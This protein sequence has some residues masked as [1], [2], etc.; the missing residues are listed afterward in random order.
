MRIAVAGLV[1]AC[2]FAGAKLARTSASAMQE[3]SGVMDAF[4]PS[5]EGAPYLALGYREA[6]ADVLFVRLRGYFGGFENTADSIAELC[7]AIV[8]LDPRFHRPYEYCGGAMTLARQGVDQSSYL[9][10]AA[11]LERGAREFPND[12]RLPNLA[13]QIY[14]QDLQ[15]D[16]P[17]Q[18]RAWQE[19]GTLLVESAIRRPGAPADLA[20]W[21]AVMRTKFGQR[22]RAI[23]E[24][25]EVLLTTPETAARKAL[26]E[27]L[28]KL[29]D[30]NADAIAVEIYE[31]RRSFQR[32][33]Q[34]E[35]PEI[36]ATW[37]VLLGPRPQMGFAM[38]DL[39]T[40][41]RDLV[42]SSMVEPVEPVE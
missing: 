10:A 9:R 19:K 33:W 23:R 15:S 3:S 40:G 11:L 28:A 34:Q 7:E 12:W 14:T 24:L 1:A 35:R 38:G 31:A 37:F 16:D 22:E 26:I 36:P 8:A 42:T 4:A 20:D 30:Q 17:K 6:A 2:A 41:G 25:R 39:A 29:Q 5:P 21:A 32:Q 27:R 18:V 13:G